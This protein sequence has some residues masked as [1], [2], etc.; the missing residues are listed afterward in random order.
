MI[1][2]RHQLESQ[3]SQGLIQQSYPFFMDAYE[4]YANGD[5]GKLL[6]N[7]LDMLNN[8]MKTCGY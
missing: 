1:N 6:S 3:Q 7:E 4:A 5:S 2:Y 8:A